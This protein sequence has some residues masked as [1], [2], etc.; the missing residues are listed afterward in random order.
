MRKLIAT[1]AIA[2]GLLAACGGGGLSDDAKAEIL[3]GC[4]SSGATEN[5]C[6]CIVDFYDDAGVESPE[7]LTQG[8]VTEAATTCAGAQPGPTNT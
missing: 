6:Q 5:Q 2:T 1:A 7:D 8:L 3:Q 4:L